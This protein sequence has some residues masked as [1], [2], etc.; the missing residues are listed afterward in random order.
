ME[1]NFPPFVPKKLKCR[2]CGTLQNYVFTR[3]LKIRN[4]IVWMFCE[5]NIFPHF[6]FTA[7]LLLSY[8]HVNEVH[9][10]WSIWM[11][12]STWNDFSLGTKKMKCNDEEK[13]LICAKQQ[14]LRRDFTNYRHASS[15]NQRHKDKE[16]PNTEKGRDERLTAR[17]VPVY[18][19]SRET[20]KHKRAW[21]EIEK[22]I[23]WIKVSVME[24]INLWEGGCDSERAHVQSC[25][26]CREKT[27][28]QALFVD[29]NSKPTI[30]FVFKRLKRAASAGVLIKN[31][32][33]SKQSELRPTERCDV[34]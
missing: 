17:C 18:Q 9:F 4:K 26:G 12:S 29:R 33:K 3:G 19:S 30:L 15:N 6:V 21:A 13:V 24:E 22:E 10:K 8:F 25:D 5:R 11:Q 28:R 23:K 1:S 14:T 32:L 7:P 31:I 20:V 2:M 16:E 34:D 27:D